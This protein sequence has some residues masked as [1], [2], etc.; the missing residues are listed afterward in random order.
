[1]LDQ[2]AD[3]TSPLF[4]PVAGEQPAMQQQQQVQPKDETNPRAAAVLPV[5]ADLRGSGG[6][7]MNPPFFA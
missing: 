6:F 7:R 1:L 3:S 4:Q 2:Y 5:E